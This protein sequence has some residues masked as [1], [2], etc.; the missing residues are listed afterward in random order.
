MNQLAIRVAGLGKRYHIGGAPA[1]YRTL[2]ESLVG[3]ARASGRALRSVAGW[4][5]RSAAAPGSFWALK[6]VSF[7]ARRG[8]VLGIIG[9]NGAGKSTLLKLLSRI[10]RPTEGRADIYGRV[11]SL[12]EV[13]TGFH[14]ELSGR[15]NVALNGAL[16]GMSRRE[17]AARFDEIVAFAEVELF[18][19]TPVKRYSSGMYLRLAF[20][21]AAHLEPEILIVDEVLAVG[22]AGFQKKCLGKMGAVASEGRTVL[23]VSHDMTNVAVLCNRVLLLEGGQVQMLGEPAEVISAYM[24]R[25]AAAS[26]QARWDLETAPGDSVA[27]IVAVQ[28]SGSGV[29]AAGDSFPL[30]GALT[31]AVEFVVLSGGV[32]LNPVFVVKNVLGTTVFSTANYTD[33]QWGTCL[34]P[35]GRYR[36]DCTVP[37]HLLNDGGYTVDVL[38]VQDMRTVR[39]AAEATVAFHIYDDGTTRGDYVGDWVG[40]VRPNCA[41]KTTDSVKEE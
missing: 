18:I 15:E 27:R 39:A 16:L 17:I 21:V 12:L 32:R 28:A 22:D 38:L 1:R 26:P 19:D 7:E 35:P 33:P 31:L 11:G 40:I 29:G 4:G 2:R 3:V 20:A 30:Q 36:A 14:P 24:R 13:G 10:T 25:G 41:W 6:D 37:P 34:Y 5:K 8:T 23:F 9:R